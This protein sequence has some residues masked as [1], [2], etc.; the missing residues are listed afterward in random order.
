MRGAV[1]LLTVLAGTTMLVAA[2]ASILG[3][4]FTISASGGSA[5]SGGDDPGAGGTG[6]SGGTTTTTGMNGGGGAE[7]LCGNG[8]VDDGETCDGDCPSECFDPDLCTHDVMMGTPE[9]C[10]V[11]CSF[12]PKLTCVHNDGCCPTGCQPGNDN[13]CDL[14]VIVIARD[15]AITQVVGTIQS[16]GDFASVV[17]HNVAT[18]GMPTPAMLAGYEAAFVYT[19][20][21][22]PDPV[23]MGDML[24][25]F[26]DAGGRVVVAN[27]AN[28]D[29]FGIEGRFVTGG[30]LTIT[31]GNAN[32]NEDSM[33]IVED[34]SPLLAGVGSL[35]VT[36]HCD[37]VAAPGATVVASLA[38]SGDPLITRGEINGRKRVD[39]NLIPYTNTA[40]GDLGPL[41][42]N[43][44]RYQ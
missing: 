21:S 36:L 24:A 11:V 1:D 4:D 25:D 6:G 17:G 23:L 29:S 14:D 39:L 10:N 32:P 30:Y 8:M 37:G 19:N 3:D 38:T 15:S 34:Q 41:L 33:V 22:F 20:V 13:E 44:I 43:A 18:M 5:G 12:E 9:D 7:P 40:M 2:C 28:C 27:G 16:T 35:T 42:S 31:K 26:H